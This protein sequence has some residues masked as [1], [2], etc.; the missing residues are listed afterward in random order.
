MVTDCEKFENKAMLMEKAPN[1]GYM[2]SLY[3]AVM[4]CTVSTINSDTAVIASCPGRIDSCCPGLR[5]SSVDDTGLCKG[6]RG[7]AYLSR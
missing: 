6:Q 4:P 7:M 2:T 3:C 5:S 1:S